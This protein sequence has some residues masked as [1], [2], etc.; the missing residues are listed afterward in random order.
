[1]DK[2]ELLL[3]LRI[4]TSELKEPGQRK[5]LES[6]TREVDRQIPEP[7]PIVCSVII[8]REKLTE[9]A[10]QVIKDVEGR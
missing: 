2:D 3:G 4:L 6:L 10:K 9:R 1:M 5:L 8:D 7:K